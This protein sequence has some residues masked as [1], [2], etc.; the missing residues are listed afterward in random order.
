M[1][2]KKK[3]LFIVPYPVKKAPSQRFRVE[4]FLPYLDEAQI[5]YDIAP[6]ID[7]HTWDILY[8]KG[9]LPAK[10]W[11]ICKA[12]IIRLFTIL[13]K[14]YK[15][16]YIF[17][18][19]EAAPLG[20]P[21]FEWFLAR[22][23]RK[24]II[25]DF[26]DAIW[27]PNTTNENRIASILKSNWKVKYICKW[28]Y[29]VVGG[30]DYLCAFAKQYNSN[31][32]LIP[33]CVDM[34]RMH[35]GTKTFDDSVVNIGWTGS[36]STLPYLNMVTDVLKEIEEEYNTNFIV[37]ANKQPS[38]PLKNLKFIPWNEQTEIEDLLKIDIGIMPLVADKWSEGK[39][40]FKLI[41]Y[42]SLG[43]PSVASPVGVNKAIISEG[44]TGFLCTTNDE[45]KEALVKL[46]K[47]SSLRKQI[48]LEGQKR[49][50]GH[51][52]TNAHNKNFIKLF[53]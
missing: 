9:A 2:N 46:I 44:V 4:L 7:E 53:E 23:L 12:Y 30:N 8:K 48:G 36:H 26:D 10:I 34:E 21:V 18:H 11:G 39:C 32:V 43:I 29:K 25:Y 51:Y 42:L 47:S 27:I 35:K 24:K 38:L 52:S 45:W 40:G 31:V 20:P 1:S 37:I 14:A 50:S 19:R 33:T 41:Q 17:L 16:Q 6:F 13:F 3:I 49:I 28:A 15:Y 5:E 22:V